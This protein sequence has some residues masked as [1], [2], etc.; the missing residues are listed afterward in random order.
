MCAK[1]I[2]H[3]GIKA[4]IYEDRDNRWISTGEEYLSMNAI[5]ILKIR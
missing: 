1:L 4:V 3:A 2:H 5:D